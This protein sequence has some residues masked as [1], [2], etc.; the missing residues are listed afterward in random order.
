MK[1]VLQSIVFVLVMAITGCVSVNSSK[2]TKNKM[3]SEDLTSYLPPDPDD[4]L[5]ISE[6]NGADMATVDT[7]LE[8]TNRL[9]S[10]LLVVNEFNS[11]TKNY[12]EGL[13]MQLYAGND[14]SEAKEAQMKAFRY[15]PD[16]HPKII[17]DQ[18]N[19][20][21][22]MGTFYT[23]LEAYP[24]YRAVQTRFPKAILVPIRIPVGNN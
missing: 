10:V 5:M 3:Y 18:P 16:S 6:N 1:G 12:V 9:D 21:V 20:K 8:V 24:M 13:S 15:F 19:Y 23:H 22:R 11:E 14:R 7:T 4:T 17:F 2:S